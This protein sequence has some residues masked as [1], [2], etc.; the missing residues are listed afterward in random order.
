MLYQ[1][2]RDKLFQLK[3]YGM[4]QAMEDIYKHSQPTELS[5]TELLAILADAECLLRENKKIGRL[6]EGA[7]F[8]EREACIEALDYKG[9]RGLTKSAVMDLTQNQWIKNNQNIFITGPS[10]SGK[11]FLAQALGRHCARHGYTVAYV[12]MPKLAFYL[13][14][15]KANGSYLDYLKKLAKHRLLIL[16]DFG[17]TSIGEQDQHDLLEII[18]DRHQV[19]STII[20]SQLPVTGWHQYLGGGLAGE[21]ILDRLHHSTHRFALRSIE[22]L[23]RDP[24]LEKEKLTQP[25]QSE[26]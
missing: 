17:I 24:S 3:L 18:E 4:V 10:G 6:I 5:P 25:G 22:S 20:T 16:D 7:K 19:G 1:Q 2:T 12:R 15:A 14:E 23:R 13:L 11:S 26:K 8:K 21:A 9:N